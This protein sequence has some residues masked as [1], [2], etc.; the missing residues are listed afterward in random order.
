MYYIRSMTDKKR[1]HVWIHASSQ[2]VLQRLADQ[3]GISVGALVDS[4]AA[5]LAGYGEGGVK[6][7]KSIP[8]IKDQML[9]VRLPSDLKQAIG[10]RSEAAGV[11]A[12]RWCVGALRKAAGD[13]AALF[14]AELDGLQRALGAMLA[15]SRDLRA[16]AAGGGAVKAAGLGRLQKKFEAASAQ[17]S[18][19]IKTVTKTL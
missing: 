1:L 5:K 19:L 15:T 3:E 17:I 18:E 2:E 11:S 6:A 9:V 12:S 14:P 13:K 10:Q 16:S 7:Y 4:I 8:S